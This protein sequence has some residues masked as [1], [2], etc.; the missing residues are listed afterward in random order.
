MVAA[1]LPALA[2]AEAEADSGY[3][4]QP[5]YYCRDTNTSI[6]AE[7]CVPGFTT[8]TKPVELAVKNVVDDKYCYTQTQTQC[9]ETT[10]N[11]DR[12]ICTYTYVS[13][14]E[15]RDATTTKVTY[16]EKSET[17]KVTTCSASEYGPHVY[18]KPKHGHGEHQY[19]REEYQTQEYR[20][21]KVDQ[22]LEVQ[23]DVAVP[24][25]VK[26]C[27]TKAIEITEVICQDITAEKCIDLVKFED[28]TVA[29]DQTEVILGEPDCKQVRVNH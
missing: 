23:V 21:P 15:K 10:K 18:G 6:Y 20:V 28:G 22:P 25:P 3:A 8:E 12:E 24:D 1:F 16:E 7:V 26:E 27:V 2:L 5:K 4:H 17:M 11:V 13:K 9:E 19:C 14:A 29:V